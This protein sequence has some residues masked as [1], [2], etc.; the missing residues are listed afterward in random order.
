[1]AVECAK[2]L[3]Q[4]QL[5]QKCV[6]LQGDVR[7]IPD[8][9]RAYMAFADAYYVDPNGHTRQLKTHNHFFKKDLAF[10]FRFNTNVFLS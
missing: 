6:P 4:E 5:F 8:L 9:V 7:I 10:F 2:Q 1:V 3:L